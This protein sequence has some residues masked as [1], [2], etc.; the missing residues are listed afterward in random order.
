MTTLRTKLESLNSE[1]GPF[2]RRTE[3]TSH[4]NTVKRSGTALSG[5]THSCFVGLKKTHQLLHYAVKLIAECMVTYISARAEKD[6]ALCMVQ[7]FRTQHPSI[8]DQTSL[9]GTNVARPRK[10]CTILP[11]PKPCEG[12]VITGAH[13]LRRFL[14]PAIQVYA[15]TG[16]TR[17]RV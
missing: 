3:T 13:M 11:L 16:S 4:T 8:T 17:T 12:L 7:R 9:N 2:K 14:L 6:Q 10:P 15:D 1:R 5:G